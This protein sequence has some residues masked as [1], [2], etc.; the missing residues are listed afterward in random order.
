M[1]VG[2]K[3]LKIV[4]WWGFL[5]ISF[6]GSIFIVFIVFGRSGVEGEALVVV[7]CSVH[8]RYNS[9][10][11]NFYWNIKSGKSYLFDFVLAA[12]RFFLHC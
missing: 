12:Y 6:S 4:G 11:T 3:T 2:I 7:V 8:I 5:G 9:L 10:T 1:R